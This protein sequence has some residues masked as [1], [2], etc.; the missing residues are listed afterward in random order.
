VARAGSF[1]GSV[2]APFG[3]KVSLD[4]LYNTNSSPGGVTTTPGPPPASPAPPSGTP[5]VSPPPVT[6]VPPVQTQQPTPSSPASQTDPTLIG[7]GAPPV[8]YDPRV[9]DT[10]ANASGGY[11]LP[12][13]GTTNPYAGAV[14]TAK[15]AGV[16]DDVLKQ[17][18]SYLGL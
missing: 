13:A 7:G 10:T 2:L 12:G 15:A 6:N 16:S 1:A 5:I 11:T 8:N 9:Q 18:N 14:D 3:G 4:A 17:F